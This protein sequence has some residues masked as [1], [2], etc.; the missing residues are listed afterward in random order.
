[1]IL[2]RQVCWPRPPARGGWRNSVKFVMTI[3][4][5]ILFGRGQKHVCIFLCAEDTLARRRHP[6]HRQTNKGSLG[7]DAFRLASPGGSSAP[8]P[9][10]LS[11]G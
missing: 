6:Q 9:A 2:L 5:M 1:M 7:D 4:I 8:S 11:L 3:F 10:A